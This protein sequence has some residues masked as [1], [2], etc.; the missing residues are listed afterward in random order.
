MERVGTDKYKF[1]CMACQK[2]LQCDSLKKHEINETH[3][4]QLVK[5]TEDIKQKKLTLWEEGFNNQ[6]KITAFLV[7]NNLPLSLGEKI[8]NL[9][10]R[11]CPDSVNSHYLTL[12]DKIVKNIASGLHKY[13]HEK[14][15]ETIGE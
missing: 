7:N 10:K 6:I 9:I 3:I 13:I 14:T 1:R 11:C 8:S 2:D 4:Q 5:Y 15:L 12:N